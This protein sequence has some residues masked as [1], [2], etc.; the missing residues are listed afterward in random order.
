MSIKYTFSQRRAIDSRGENLLISASA[1]SGKT[2]TMVNRIISLIEEGESLDRMLILTFTKAAASDMRDKISRALIEK[3]NAS[4]HFERQLHILPAARIGTFDSWCQTVVKN[5][6]YAIGAASDFQL[7]DDAENRAIADPVIT[8]LIERRYEIDDQ[9]FIS[10][11]E[12]MVSNRS[13]VMFR[14]FVMRLIEFADTQCE[15]VEWLQSCCRGYFTDEAEK[16]V[17]AALENDEKKILGELNA[18]G[19]DAESSG[20]KALTDYCKYLATQMYDYSGR[21]KPLRGMELFPV[22]GKRKAILVDRIKE[23]YSRREQIAGLPDLK[24]SG[25][26]AL[27]AARFA[28]EV[29][30]E[31]SRIKKERAQVTYADL[32]HY[33]YDILRDGEAGAEIRESIRYTFIDEYQDVNPLQDALV[34]TA[35]GG[36]LYVVGDVKQSIYAFRMSE[37]EIFLEKYYRPEENGFDGVIE[38]AENFRSSGAV[39]DFTNSV[40]ENI[41][42]ARFGGLDY[43]KV[44]LIAS[45]GD[46]GGIAELRLL[47]KKEK[48]SEGEE[49]AALPAVYSVKNAP[50][51]DSDSGREMAECVAKGIADLL[52]TSDG[53]GHIIEPGDIAVLYRSSSPVLRKLYDILRE[54]GVNVYLQEKSYF[55]EAWEVRCIDAF[56]RVLAF[57]LDEVALTA[58]LL[59]PF[60]GLDERDLH[61]IAG[62][63]RVTFGE[64]VRAYAAMEDGVAEKVRHALELIDRYGERARTE[65]VVEIVTDLVAESGYLSLLKAGEDGAFAAQTVE[66]YIVYLSGI[67]SART[68]PEY[69]RFMENGKRVCDMPAPEGALKITTIHASKGLEYPYVFLLGADKRFNMRDLHSGYLL[70]RKAGLC[71]TTVFGGETRENYVTLSARAEMEKKL[72]EENM[73]LLYVAM[74]RAEKGLFVYAYDNGKTDCPPQEAD[75]YL[76]WLRCGNPVV[77]W[78]QPPENTADK[79]ALPENKRQFAGYSEKLAAEIKKNISFKYPYHSKNIKATVTGMANEESMTSVVPTE[80]EERLMKKGTLYHAI[81]ER[82]DFA[83]PFESEKER[84]SGILGGD[85]EWDKIAAAHSAVGA[86]VAKFGGKQYREQSFIAENDGALIQ[87]IIDLLLINGDKAIILDYKLTGDKHILKDSYI[88]QLNLYASAVEKIIG[89]RTEKLYLYSFTSETL[90]EVPKNGDNAF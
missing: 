8:R 66:K 50:K 25:E 78:L 53:N 32:E 12:S 45:K 44:K 79:S 62:V 48:N 22:L 69:V 17:K 28:V 2:T 36:L 38:F 6:F 16:A 21:L 76:D 58:F 43:E 57:G 27:A 59:S 9:D 29:K 52:G 11:Y 51:D 56:L 81:M 64:K 75:C 30:K 55:D 31:M 33:A 35:S 80:D 40:F 86:L 20:C 3:R 41:M 73:R 61:K 13:D 18:L 74:T 19:S 24:T 15:P 68:V 85:A 70:D 26:Q 83:A 67:T 89:K 37:P 42:S 82:I 65:T 63:R 5:Y 72:K 77:R 4:E 46:D 23:Y 7:I 49:D 34:A 54:G 60:A 84:L 14:E 39:V 10:V 88:K 71:M 90:V 1:G 47:P 87:G